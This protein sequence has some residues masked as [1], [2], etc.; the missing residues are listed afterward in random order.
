MN[1]T[2]V[3]SGSGDCPATLGEAWP[4]ARC[5]IDTVDARVLV[6]EASGCNDGRWI[7]HGETPLSPAQ[8]E[9]LA[10]WVTRRMA[11]EPIAYI[12]GWRE[13]H[14]HRFTVTPDVLIPR[15]DTETLVDAALAMIPEDTP[16]RVLDLGTGSGCVAVS[17][18]LARPRAN[19]LA[20]DS[21][22][23]ALA[24]ARRN[25]EALGAANVRFARGD[26]YAAAEA[27]FDIIVSNPP[28]IAGRDPHLGEG[29]LR[30]EP[31]AALTPGGDGLDALRAIIAGAPAHLGPGGWLL[32]EHGWD[33]G[34][35]VAALLGEA[36]M[37]VRVDHHDL[38]GNHRVSGARRVG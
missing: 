23:Q 4:W 31:A 28:Y 1:S 10:S 26:W 13:F 29:D 17:I 19:V 16:A 34:L 14:G 20:T 15:P 7:S 21:S 37:V 24:V 12:L 33:Q 32:V 35:A 22:V 18:A 8:R 38:G 25:A 30:F 5:Q 9:R 11:G 2:G 3:N 36:G 27:L 6:R